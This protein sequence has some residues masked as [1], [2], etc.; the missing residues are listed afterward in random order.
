[1]NKENYSPASLLSHMSKGFERILYNQLNYFMKD[2]LSNI[3]TGFQKGHSV[4]HL[5]YI[6]TEKWKRALDEDMNVRAI[7]MNLSRVVDTLNH[8]LSN[9]TLSNGF[10]IIENW[11]HQNLMVLN[12]KKC[13]YMRFGISS[14]NDDFIFDRI[15][16]PNSC[17]RG[18]NIR[19]SS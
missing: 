4:Q 3:L 7:F 1:M 14:E 9:K 5:S 2:K 13:H 17:G 18:E 11:F 19:N 12:A 10:R 6:M 8:I 16:L 15:K